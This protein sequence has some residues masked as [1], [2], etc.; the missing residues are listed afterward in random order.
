MRNASYYNAEFLLTVARAPFFP[1]PD[2]N[3]ELLYAYGTIDIFFFYSV[4]NVVIL[5]GF[6]AF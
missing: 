6:A 3:P 4:H 5:Y 1:L 2:I